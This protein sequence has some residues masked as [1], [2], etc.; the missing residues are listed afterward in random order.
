MT[1]TTSKRPPRNTRP[2]PAPPIEQSRVL[3]DADD[4]PPPSGNNH[5]CVPFPAAWKIIE[6]GIAPALHAIL[7]I[8]GQPVLSCGGHQ[9]YSWWVSATLKRMTTRKPWVVVGSRTLADLLVV[10]NNLLLERRGPLAVYPIS[11]RNEMPAFLAQIRR[12]APHA[13]LWHLIIFASRR[14]VLPLE[15][16][17]LTQH[18]GG[19]E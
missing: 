1:P 17:M 2:A 19:G 9:H 15:D 7:A 12:A 4:R 11:L 18:R 6:A 16:Q 13:R 3:D 5:S 10:L 14:A 8:G